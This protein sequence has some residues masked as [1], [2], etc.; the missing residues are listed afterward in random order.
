M[1]HSIIQAGRSITAA[2]LLGV[3]LA[4]VPS[5]GTLAAETTTTRPEGADRS[6]SHVAIDGSDRSEARIQDLRDKLRITPEQSAL[7]DNV[8]Q[9]MRDNGA[10]FRSSA[11]DRSNRLREKNLTAVDDLKSFQLITDQHASGLRRLIPAFEALYAGMAPDQK[12]RADK[13]FSEH[14]HRSGSSRM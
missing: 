3:F 14:E 11:R 9:I 1:S 13:V 5:H 12:R 10:A 4:T 6:R 8:A 2:T 7:W